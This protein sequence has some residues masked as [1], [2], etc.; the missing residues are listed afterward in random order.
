MSREIQTALVTGANRGL[1]LE[2]A[3]QLAARG[4]RVLLACRDR[5]K[6]IAAAEKLRG[7]GGSLEVEELDVSDPRSVAALA[8]RLRASRRTID[9]LVNNAAIALDGFNLDVARRTIDT[10]FYGPVRLSEALLP[11]MSDSGSIVMVSSGAGE[12]SILSPALRKRFLDPT[13]TREGLSALVEQFVDHVRRGRHEAEGWPTS[14][15]GVSKAGLNA[16]VRILAPELAARG[17][18][19]NAVCPGWVRTDMGGASASRSVAEG[20]SSI[21]WAALAETRESGGFFR[22]GKPI[23]W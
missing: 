2:T 19:L 20:A 23:P 11:S 1:G 5:R 22:Y 21:V 13:L 18:R 3:R 4:F 8:A 14:A 17:I 10:N 6:G 7:S 12:L 16:Y 9:A 15:Y